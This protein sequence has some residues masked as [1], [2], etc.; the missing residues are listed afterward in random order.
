MRFNQKIEHKLIAHN[1]LIVLA[2]VAFSTAIV[3]DAAAAGFG[4]GGGHGSGEFRGGYVGHGFRG[5][6]VRV[7]SMPAPTFNPSSPYTLPEGR[8]SP[9]SPASPG[10]IFGNG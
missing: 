1:T 3:T 2:A 6:L 4:S 10:S 9:V 7:P 5:P 8:E